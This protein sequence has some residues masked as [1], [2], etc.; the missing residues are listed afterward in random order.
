MI[1]E[2]AGVEDAAEILALQRLAYQS[3]AYIYP[4]HVL[5][6][7]KQ[8]LAEIEAEFAVQTFLKARLEGRRRP[9]EGEIV[10]SV[11][12]RMEGGTC[13][14]GRLIVHP[15]H[16]NQGIGTRLL[17]TVERTFPNAER[18]E[19]FTGHQSVRNLSLYEKLGYRIFRREEITP[20][21]TRVFLEK[22][23]PPYRRRPS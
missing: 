11:R 6:P 20:H 17:E 12:A 3:E 2:Q 5:A 18:F 9:G 15:H 10:G 4:D 23:A 13:F 7:L 1:I 22:N 14:I 19:L 8:T 21:L 16:Q